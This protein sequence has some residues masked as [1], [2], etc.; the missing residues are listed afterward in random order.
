MANFVAPS[1]ELLSSGAWTLEEFGRVLGNVPAAAYVCDQDGLI[2]YFNRRAA[3]IWGRE[4]FLNDS[5]D[6]YCGS[7]RIFTR[8]GAPLSHEKCWMAR[9]LM[10]DREFNGYE[11][12]IEQPSGKRVT[13]L[14][15]ATP[16]HG[17]DGTLLGA[18]NVIVDISDQKRKEAVKDELLASH[19]D[20]CK[21]R[22]DWKESD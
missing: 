2:T 9:A 4:P 16:V 6:R 17:Q 22:F 7:S 18:V 11:L 12:V 8:E 5:R 13:T 15:H 1:A 3:E 10:E 21:K 19:L 20:S 14:A